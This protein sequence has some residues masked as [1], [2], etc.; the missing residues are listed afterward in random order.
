MKEK[1]RNHFAD[2]P[3]AMLSL[4]L[5]GMAAILVLI[6]MQRGHHL[7]KVIALVWVILP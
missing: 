7:E 2:M 1:L 6:A 3:D 4:M 5:L